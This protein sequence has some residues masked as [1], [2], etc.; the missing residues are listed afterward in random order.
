MRWNGLRIFYASCTG[1][2]R[3]IAAGSEGIAHSTIALNVKSEHEQWAT[4]SPAS[5]ETT[6][7]LRLHYHLLIHKLE[8]NFA[9]G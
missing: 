7:P 6:H 9:L 2:F 5:L 3:S 4:N 1:G 8:V